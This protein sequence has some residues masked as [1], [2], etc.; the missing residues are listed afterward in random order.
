LAN[1]YNLKRNP[2]FSGLFRISK[3]QAQPQTPHVF[4]PMSQSRQTTRIA[5]LFSSRLTQ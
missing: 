2:E 1:N 3:G 4:E 5:S